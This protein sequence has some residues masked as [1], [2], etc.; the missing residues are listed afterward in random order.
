MNKTHWWIFVKFNITYAHRHYH[1]YRKIAIQ[2]SCDRRTTVEGKWK[3]V[4]HKELKSV[5]VKAKQA[6]LK[7][8]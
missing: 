8:D 7:V 2:I 5:H 4:V 6:H 3:Y 1:V